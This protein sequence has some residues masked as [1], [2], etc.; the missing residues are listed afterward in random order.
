MMEWG[1]PVLAVVLLERLK[2]CSVEQGVWWLC[3]V[4]DGCLLLVWCWLGR[5]GACVHMLG[6]WRGIWRVNIDVA[7]SENSPL[8]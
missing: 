7:L 1:Q 3:D 8:F 6:M 5:L 4:A 2:L